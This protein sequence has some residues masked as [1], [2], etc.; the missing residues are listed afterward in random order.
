MTRKACKRK[1]WTPNPNMVGRVISGVAMVSERNIDRMRL[2]EL[3]QIDALQKGAGTWQDIVGMRDMMNVT[4]TI[5]DHGIGP[6]AL[7]ACAVAQ[8]AILTII[9]RYQKWQKVQ[10]TDA[11]ITALREVHQYADLQRQSVQVVDFERFVKITQAR[12]ETGHRRVVE[13]L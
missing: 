6:E 2:V 9:A 10:A 8:D 11:E 13:V 7:P 12:I 1:V 4:E 3:S 5:A